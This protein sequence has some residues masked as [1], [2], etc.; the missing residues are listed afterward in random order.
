MAFRGVAV[1]VAVAGA[2]AVGCGS[3]VAAPGSGGGAVEPSRGWYPVDEEWR[4]APDDGLF[5]PKGT[6]C[7]GFDLRT[8]P[9]FQAVRSKV[10]SRWSEGAVRTTS[11]RGPLLVRATNEA[12]GRSAVV[13]LSGRSEVLTRPDATIAVYTSTGPIGMGWPQDGGGL[14]RGFHV[15]KGHHVTTFGADGTRRLAVDRGPE[16]D[17]C[18]LVDGRS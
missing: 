15:L 7:T 8:T 9:E 18:R 1:S 6:Y 5:L 11:Y 16:V 12:T 3:A 2:V 13:N 17:V 4:P 14:E 10:T